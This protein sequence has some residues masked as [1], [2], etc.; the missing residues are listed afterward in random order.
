MAY[1]SVDFSNIPGTVLNHSVEICQ[2]HA[3]NVFIYM[4]KQ[5]VG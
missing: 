1:G 4:E 5:I 3:Q 2:I